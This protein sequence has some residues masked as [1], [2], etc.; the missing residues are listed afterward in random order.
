MTP[1]QSAAVLEVVAATD[2]GRVREHNED[3]VRALTA[4]A[5][6]A[7]WQVAGVLIVADGMGG[8]QAGEVAS[9]LAA[10]ALEEFFK[11]PPAPVGGPASALDGRALLAHL[12]AA[13]RQAN[14][15]VFS[16]VAPTGGDVPTTARPGTTLTACLLR[17]D[18]YFIG[19]VG[20]SRAYLLRAEDEIFSCEQITDD[21]SFVG[22]AVRNGHMT[23]EDAR[24]SPLRHQITKA[25]GLEAEVEP[26]LH[27]GQWQ[28][29]EVLLLCSDGLTEYVE[30][31]ELAAIVFTTANLN[32]AC[33]EL[34]A[35]ANSRGGADNIS[36]CAARHTTSTAAPGGAR[37]P[38][39][40]QPAEI[41]ELENQTL[42]SAASKSAA[43][44][45]AALKS[46]AAKSGAPST[47][48]PLPGA[49]TGRSTQRPV[50]RP[51]ESAAM[52]AVHDS[53]AA[54]ESRLQARRQARRRRDMIVIGL[55]VLCAG[56][57][58][59]WTWKQRAASPASTS[60]PVAR[61]T[62]PIV[63]KPTF[64][65]TVGKTKSGDLK[66]MCSNNA[67]LEF[68]SVDKTLSSQPLSLQVVRLILADKKLLV[69]LDQ[70]QRKWTLACAPEA[71]PSGASQPQAAP[72][73]EPQVVWRESATVEPGR[74]YS[75][76]WQA[77]VETTPA[78]ASVKPPAKPQVWARF[79][80]V[81]AK[82]TP[83]G[84]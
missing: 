14:A 69:Q 74:E 75:L 24:H 65:V 15:A 6:D 56:T 33:E 4:Q 2:V 16:S 67:R 82:S 19:H 48:A 8:H 32:T 21:D 57:L 58:A 77:V 53:L 7:L 27:H 51:Y 35:L 11:N 60:P 80:L 9:G 84:R 18:E 26:A 29:G 38:P 3:S 72:V 71:K 47:N 62:T 70:D 76:L 66:I 25:I 40:L 36:L 22:E 44:K 12:D 46:G 34:I 10:D 23:P 83:A 43:F 68:T 59:A 5:T 41:A 81:P 37:K 64:G 13:V 39:S 50:V 78:G 28:A 1:N 63:P 49:V 79:R 61:R 17:A 31:E 73:A 30:D 20:D 55:V 52:R 45:S 42:E 54:S